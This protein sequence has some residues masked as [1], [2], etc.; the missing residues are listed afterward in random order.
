MADDP[1]D[2]NAAG[3]PRLK[4]IWWVVG[5]VVIAWLITAVASGLSKHDSAGTFGDAF[6]S[7]NALFSGLA[8][9]GLVYAILLQRRELELQR[10]E[11]RETRAELKGSREAQEV[12]NKFIETQNFEGTFFQLLRS[13]ND[14]IQSIDLRKSGIET[15]RGRDAIALFYNRLDA[16]MVRVRDNY[17]AGS[18]RLEMVID[19]YEGFYKN[20]R[21]ELGHYFRMLYNVFKFVDRSQVAD[22]MRYTHIARAQ[23][24]DIEANLLLYNC[25]TDRAVRFKALAEKYHLL[26]YINEERLFDRRDRELLPASS[27]ED[28][29]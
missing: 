6:G 26:R 11:L 24:S 28:P 5:F 27:F 29:V 8:F 7:V 9:V 13:L 21:H 12:Q 25:L 15:A 17:P 14:I 22:K 2:D 19:A 18:D 10:K 3:D 16:E 1:A 4:H 23:M 20:H